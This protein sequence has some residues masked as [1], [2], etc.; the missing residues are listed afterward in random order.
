MNAELL[1]RVFSLSSIYARTTA[2]SVSQSVLSATS[3]AGRIRI[4]TGIC[5]RI[6]MKFTVSSGTSRIAAKSTDARENL[7]ADE[8]PRHANVA[9]TAKPSNGG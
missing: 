3:A 9:G 6:S 8:N 4:N 1:L 5:A 7:S 2:G